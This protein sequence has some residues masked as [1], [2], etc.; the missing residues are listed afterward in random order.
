MPFNTNTK[1]FFLKGKITIYFHVMQ[2]FSLCNR[3]IQEVSRTQAGEPL[4]EP[5]NFSK[6]A[7]NRLEIHAPDRLHLSRLDGYK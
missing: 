7:V 1:Q 4:Q 3:D 6:P 2:Q 5:R